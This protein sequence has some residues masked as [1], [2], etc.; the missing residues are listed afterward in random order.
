MSF[1]A[2]LLYF[3]N[4]FIKESEICYRLC[5]DFCVCILRSL[6]ALYINWADLNIHRVQLKFHLTRDNSVNSCGI[7]NSF[8]PI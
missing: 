7:L 8:I 5:Y 6:T 3:K 2:S 1:L 4:C